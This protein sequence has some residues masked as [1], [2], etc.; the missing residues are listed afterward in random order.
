MAPT[1]KVKRSVVEERY[2]QAVA[3]AGNDRNSHIVWL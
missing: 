2:G 1:M 3:A